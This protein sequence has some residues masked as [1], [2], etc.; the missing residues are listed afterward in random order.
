MFGFGGRP[1]YRPFRRGYGFNNF[2]LPFALGALTGAFF[3]PPYFYRPF[4]YNS[5]YFYY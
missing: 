4:P 1:F 3:T 2:G 5:P